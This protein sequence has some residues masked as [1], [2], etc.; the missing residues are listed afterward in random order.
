MPRPLLSVITGTWQRHVLLMGAIDTVREQTYRPLE[1]VIVS[2]GQDAVL[3][4]SIARVQAESEPDDP[5]IRFYELGRNWSSVIPES[6]SAPPF[7]TAQLLAAGEYISWLSDDERFL[8]SDALTILADRL[9]AD[10]LDFVY[11]RVSVHLK[12]QSAEA[13]D[14]GV[15]PPQIGT[16]THALH[17]ADILNVY[18]GGFRCSVGSGSDWDQ[19][20]RWM[21]AGKR[22]AMVGQVLLSHRIDKR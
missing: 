9:E 13:W 19:F 22:G 11:P 6:V 3:R 5:P 16:V 15:Y 20:A 12:G 17:R 14:I 1:H 2:D 21:A 7:M 18:G 4:R 10:G 8:S